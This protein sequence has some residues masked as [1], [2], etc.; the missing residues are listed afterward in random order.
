[1]E[2]PK[3]KKYKIGDLYNVFSGLSKPRDQFG[4]GH[5]FVTFKDVFQ[6]YFLPGELT[7]LVNTN[8][9]E[10]KSCS[11]KKGDVFLTRTSETQHELGMSSVALKDY[12]NAT[13]NGFTKRLRLKDDVQV[14][15]DLLYLGYFLRSPFFR[16]QVAQHSSLT[17]RASLNATAINSME[18]IFPEIDEQ[19]KIGGILKSLDDKIDLN[20]QTAQILEAIAQALFKEWFVDFNFPG[21]TGEMEESELGMIPKGWRVGNLGELLNFRNGKA[22]PNRGEEFTFPVY[23]ANGIIGYTELFNCKPNASIVGRVGSYCGVVYYTT[24]K[25]FVTENAIVAES[26]YEGSSLYCYNKLL[27]LNLNNHK[28]G[29]GQPLLNQAILSSIKLVIPS[30]DLVEKFED[31]AINLKV[32]A[33]QSEYQSKTLTQ[34]RDSLLPKLM[35]NH[36]AIP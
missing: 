30:F 20:R 10:I 27:S 13:F 18:V 25:A 8:E 14:E 17:T 31:V 24:E 26:K 3:W 36:L 16:D 32:Q 2:A 19:R 29:S 4:F 5:P 23:G 12:P 28:S 35:S 6:N 9:K 22:S 1:M 34:L 21:A 33:H 15:I 11:V 7:S